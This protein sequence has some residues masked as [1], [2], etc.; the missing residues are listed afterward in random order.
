LIWSLRAS[1]TTS[2]GV[3]RSSR[4]T[5]LGFSPATQKP[6]HRPGFFVPALVELKIAWMS[7]LGQIEKNSA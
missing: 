4:S 6:R 7:Q 3:A 5:D 2:T 1:T